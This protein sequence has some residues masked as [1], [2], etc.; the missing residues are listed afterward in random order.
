MKTVLSIIVAGIVVL[1]L[2]Y[3]A[4]ILLALYSG[5]QFMPVEEA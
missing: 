1:I 5:Q 4:G 2:G 3:I